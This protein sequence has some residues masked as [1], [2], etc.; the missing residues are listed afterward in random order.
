VERVGVWAGA[1]GAVVGAGEVGVA[2]AGDGVVV[3]DSGVWAGGVVG[4]G[5]GP[6]GAGRHTRITLTCGTTTMTLTTFIR[7]IRLTKA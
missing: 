4:D 7:T 5:A 1:G 6:S 2:A 3:G